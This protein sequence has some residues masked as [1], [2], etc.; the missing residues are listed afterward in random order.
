M[1][2]NSSI[3]TKIGSN[4]YQF[5]FQYPYFPL[6]L[7]HILNQTFKSKFHFLQQSKVFIFFRIEFFFV[8][9]SFQVLHFIPNN[10][11]KLKINNHDPIRLTRTDL[12][13]YRFYNFRSQAQSSSISIRYFYHLHLFLFSLGLILIILVF[14]LKISLFACFYIF[15]L[16]ILS[17]I[18]DV[19]QFIFSTL[20][21][22]TLMR[23]SIKIILFVL[24]YIIQ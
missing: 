11:Q 17:R 18:I 2:Q 12:I 8:I 21:L 15:N 1:P 13:V 3:L 7:F 9:K 22:R 10:Q 5:Y 6:F 24:L 4:Y 20:S 14:E 23:Q 19:N 16:R